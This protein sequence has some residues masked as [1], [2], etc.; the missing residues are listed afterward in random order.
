MNL[1]DHNVI[2]SGNAT[3]CSITEEVEAS[4]LA[5]GTSEPFDTITIYPNPTEEFLSFNKPLNAEIEIYDCS[6]RLQKTT[7]LTDTRIDVSDLPKG[8]YYLMIGTEKERL[9][10]RFVKQ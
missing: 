2:I 8:I 1:P 10:Y 6:G 7:I 4:C 9:S 5:V 3:G